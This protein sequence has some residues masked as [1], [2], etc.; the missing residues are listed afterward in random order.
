VAATIP[1]D[2]A[3]VKSALQRARATM[4]E[5]ATPDEITEPNRARALLEHYMAKLD[6]IK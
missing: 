3:A 2:A 1:D 5:A 6:F 4:K